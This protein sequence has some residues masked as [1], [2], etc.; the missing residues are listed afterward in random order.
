M[1]EEIGVK[2][3]QIEIVKQ[4]NPQDVRTG[5]QIYPFVAFIPSDS[6]FQIDKYEV[7]KII[8]VPIIKL[9]D[10]SCYKMV[11]IKRK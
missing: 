3:D 10:T 1:R 9:L 6:Y 2:I 4:L 11:N 5:F 8:K 7:D